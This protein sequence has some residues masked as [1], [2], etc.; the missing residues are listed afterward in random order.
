MGRLNEDVGLDFP[1]VFPAFPPPPLAG[2]AFDP[3]PFPLSAAFDAVFAFSAFCLAFACCS[4]CFF[5]ASFKALAL[6]SSASVCSFSHSS[7]CANTLS[8]RFA[9]WIRT[10]SLNTLGGLLICPSTAVLRVWNLIFLLYASHCAASEE[11]SIPGSLS[12]GFSTKIRA[13]IDTSTCNRL[14]LSGSH[15]GPD[16]VPSSERHTLPHGYRFGLKCTEP[17]PVV[18]KCTSGGL[19]G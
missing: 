2:L 17:L 15:L 13:W 12:H 14:D 16:Q 1:A 3:P 7:H 19:W 11:S 5:C 9:K 18:Q 10:M 4:C 6:I 8:A